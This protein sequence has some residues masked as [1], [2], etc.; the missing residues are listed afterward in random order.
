MAGFAAIFFF[1]ITGLT[2]NHADV[3]ESAGAAAERAGTLPDSLNYKT[4]VID[5]F[6]LV[7]WLRAHERLRGAVATFDVEPDELFI[8]MKGPAYAADLHIRRDSG[9]YTINEERHGSM[10]WLDD[11]H[12]GRDSGAAWSWIID[13]SA[14]VMACAS[15]TGLWLLFFVRS[16]RNPGLVVTLLGLIILIAVAWLAVP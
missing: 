3:F 2:L 14:I 13:I 8:I 1:A 11:L 9:N 6:A 15:L 10:A 4:G 12:K 7:E 5:K 16:R